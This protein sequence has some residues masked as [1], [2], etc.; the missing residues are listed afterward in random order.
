MFKK[1]RYNFFI[2][3]EDGQY[4][5]Y[6]VKSGA[7][8]L[9]KPEKYQE[10]VS[11]LDN[12]QK[13]DELFQDSKYQELVNQLK[14]TQFLIDAEEDEV[15]I[16]EI[17]NQMAKFNTTFLSLSIA[18]TMACNFDCPYC[19]EKRTKSL[20]PEE[21]AD[22]IFSFIDTRVRYLDTIQITWYGGEPLLA[23]NRIQHLSEKILKLCQQYNINY[24]ASMTTNGYLLNKET[25]QVLKNLKIEKL[26]TT[27]DGPRE[28]HNKKR[29]LTGKK[30]TYDVIMS[31]LK[32]VAD[33]ISIM[34]R[35]NVDKTTTT[36]DIVS[37]LADLKEQGLKDK[38][39]VYFGNIE[40]MTD[41]CQNVAESCYDTQNF[42]QK[43]IEFFQTALDMDYRVQKLPIQLNAVCGAVALNSYLIDPEGLLY[44]CWNDVGRKEKAYGDVKT[45]FSLFHP[46]LYPWIS[47][48]PFK[49]KECAECNIL[50][51]CMG[52]C[53][54][55]K[56]N[57]TGKYEELNCQPWKYNLEEMLKLIAQT[58][59]KEKEVKI[60]E[61]VQKGENHGRV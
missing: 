46:N 27:L 49:R 37:L 53:P 50:P 16:L 12:P 38:I 32:E 5:A 44:K 9:L 23:L 48:N 52:G 3:W 13:I 22:A 36:E 31:N 18:P 41:V 35:V 17:F 54:Y 40:T 25:A 14:Y 24:S 61:K 7:L 60:K 15:G 1:S 58:K 6:N 4:L 30:G 26:Q 33:I 28:V 10:V 20:M 45:P 57:K 42:S 2:K 47:H 59:I 34:L 39:S 21:V 43:E 11:I 51:I 29:P 56:V 19:Y 55:P 8:A